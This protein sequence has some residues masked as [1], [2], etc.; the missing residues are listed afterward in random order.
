MSALEDDEPC[1]IINAFSI[2][3]EGDML[4]GC[5]YDPQYGGWREVKVLETIF[6]VFTTKHHI[7]YTDLLVVTNST[8]YLLST[9]SPSNENR[10]SIWFGRNEYNSMER[11]CPYSPVHNKTYYPQIVYI[12]Y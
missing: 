1:W 5:D 3:R 7:K 6:K 11:P 8:E 12:G 9:K 10:F 4:C 2:S